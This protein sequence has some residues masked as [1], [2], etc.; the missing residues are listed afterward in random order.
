V[1]RSLRVE[2]RDACEWSHTKQNGCMIWSYL[3]SQRIR[4]E[5]QAWVEVHYT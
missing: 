3:T 1:S 5:P 4:F 2:I